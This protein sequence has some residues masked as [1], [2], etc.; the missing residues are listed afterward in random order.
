MEENNRETENLTMRFGT[1]RAESR[2]CSELAGILPVS[3]H[4]AASCPILK[5]LCEPPGR[6]R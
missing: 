1:S 2:E 6:S 4:P 3:T 5:S